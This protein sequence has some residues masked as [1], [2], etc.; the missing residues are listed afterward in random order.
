MRFDIDYESKCF[1]ANAKPDPCFKY[2][3]KLIECCLFGN[4]QNHFKTY[5]RFVLEYFAFPEL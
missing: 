3:S 4:A 1:A 2:F 5:G